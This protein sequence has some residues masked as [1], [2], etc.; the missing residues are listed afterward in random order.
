MLLASV[1]AWLHALRLPTNLWCSC[2]KAWWE[3]SWGLS[4]RGRYSCLQDILGILLEL[5]CYSS[6]MLFGGTFCFHRSTPKPEF[7]VVMSEVPLRSFQPSLTPPHTGQPGPAPGT[8]GSEQCSW[9]ASRL[10]V[11]HG[12]WYTTLPLCHLLSNRCP[13]FPVSPHTHCLET[14]TVTFIVTCRGPCHPAP[15]HSEYTSFYLN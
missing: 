15:V 8:V 2:F 1:P 10:F 5:G 3:S 11:H 13:P 7:T 9:K 6:S 4:F 12:P 14:M